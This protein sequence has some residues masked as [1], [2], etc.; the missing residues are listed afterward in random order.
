[1]DPNRDGLGHTIPDIGLFSPKLQT[2]HTWLVPDQK[3]DSLTT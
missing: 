1:M 3:T 2:K